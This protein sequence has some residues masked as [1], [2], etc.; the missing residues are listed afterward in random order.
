MQRYEIKQQ[1]P[2]KC[3]CFFE[4]NVSL[5]KIIA[6]NP[7]VDFFFNKAEKWQ[8]ELIQ[9]R[10]FMQDCGLTEDAKWGVPCYSLNK[11]NICLIHAFK[12]YFA[13]LF[14]KGVLMKDAE[15]I[16]IQQT[17]NVQ[18]ARQIRFTSLEQLIE[19][20]AVLKAY[21]FEAIEIEKA[22]LKVAFK[23]T[24]EFNMP[25]EFAQKLAESE[26]LKQRF[27]SL[28]PGRQRAYLLHFSQAKQSKT[29]VARIE[30]YLDKIMDGKGLDD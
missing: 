25:E 8:D 27:E 19:M 16:L 11:K 30:K 9:L 14:M 13:V 28:T 6:M 26:R 5:E 7:K 21:V 24:A 15:N 20:E 3:C 2:D 18:S 12:D 22:G 17:E 23:K 29:R 10:M 4:E 1:E